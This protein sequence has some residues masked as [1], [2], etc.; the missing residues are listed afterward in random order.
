MHGNYALND[1]IVELSHFL[2]ED[3]INRVETQMLS[4]KI[5]KDWNLP[6]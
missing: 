3:I 4:N 6:K 5:K 1:L 2:D